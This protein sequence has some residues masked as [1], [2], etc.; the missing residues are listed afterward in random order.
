MSGFVD[1]DGDNYAAKNDYEGGRVGKEKVEHYL[2]VG[3][4]SGGAIASL[5]VFESCS[6]GIRAC[7]NWLIVS[8]LNVTSRLGGVLV[9]DVG[10]KCTDEGSVGRQS[11]IVIVGR[12]KETEIRK[13]DTGL[14]G[15]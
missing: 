1:A 14:G 6:Q 10:C 8:K 3:G 13:E 7:L 5:G 4:D 11:G 9:V 15:D 12:T 2:A